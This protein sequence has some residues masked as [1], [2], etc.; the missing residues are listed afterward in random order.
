[1]KAFFR[2]RRDFMNKE[3]INQWKN[4]NKINKLYPHFDRRKNS[5]SF[6]IEKYITNPKNIVKHSFYPFI[7]TQIIFKKFNKSNPKEPKDKKRDISYSS[8]IDRL[9][10]SYYSQLL[11]NEYN[12]YAVK[13][14]INKNVIAYRTN[15]KKNNIHFAKEVFDIIRK[16]KKCFIMVGDFKSFF[17]N[18][19]HGYL[20]KQLC[21][22]LQVEKLPEDWYIIYR[23]IT[24]YRY[25]ELEEI[26]KLL[27]ISYKKLIE[28][29]RIFTIQ[30]FRKYRKEN[31]ITI[32]KN[33]DRTPQGTLGIP[34]GSSIS[35][36]L[37]NVYMIE[38]DYLLKTY[39]YNLGGEY[40]RYSDDF[41]VIIPLRNDITSSEIKE[42]IWKIEKKIPNLK[43]EEEKTECYIYQ[44]NL[45]IS[46]KEKNYK[47]QL[48]YLG[49]SFDG[50]NIYL[51]AKTISKYY[52]RMY[53]KIKNINLSEK[54]SKK[55]NIISCDE[56]YKNYSIKSG[57]KRN[58]LNYIMR[59]EKIFTGKDNKYIKNIRYTHLKKIKRRIKKVENGRL[60][61]IIQRKK[62]N[63]KLFELF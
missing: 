13:N 52:Y 2:I 1:M 9:I 6:G 62:E 36:I 43:I 50:I 17:D 16:Y 44:E 60:N 24:K 29:E 27:N 7:H 20:K 48:D 31:K 4:K 39:T 49:F 8:H 53:K 46:E 55:G 21:K 19:E 35:A 40:F 11:N 57:G 23:N 59:A 41:I 56:L 18:L 47:V 14:N 63:S 45:L 12:N 38:F 28:K 15:L 22:V 25:C 10:Y 42:N 51:R 5:Q 58:F 3:I 26:L 32:K 34:Q 37:A 33:E 54:V 61:E 30:E